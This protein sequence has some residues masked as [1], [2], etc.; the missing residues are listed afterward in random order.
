MKSIH[1]TNLHNNQ[2]DYVK[3]P[4]MRIYIYYNIHDFRRLSFLKYFFC[5]FFVP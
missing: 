1:N 2:D 4:D 5:N 3:I